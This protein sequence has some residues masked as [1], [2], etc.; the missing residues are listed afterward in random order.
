V[1]PNGTQCRKIHN[2]QSQIQ[3]S[4]FIN[5]RSPFSVIRY[6]FSDGCEAAVNQTGARRTMEE[7]DRKQATKKNETIL[8]KTLK[9]NYTMGE[10][11]GC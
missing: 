11:T 2:P 6:P 5:H 1:K 4:S 9:R 10:I 8:E 3:N 7:A